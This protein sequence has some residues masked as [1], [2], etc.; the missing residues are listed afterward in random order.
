MGRKKPKIKIS[1]DLQRALVPPIIFDDHGDVELFKD[2]ES[3]I[4]DIEPIDVKKAGFCYYD[5]TGRQLFVSMEEEEF[6]VRDGG[7]TENG[8]ATLRGD[9][10]HMLQEIDEPAAETAEL[11]ELIRALSQSAGIRGYQW[12]R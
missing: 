12:Q 11:S 9:L 10:R 4:F 2:L 1:V 5:S 8:L 3:L 7:L 6:V